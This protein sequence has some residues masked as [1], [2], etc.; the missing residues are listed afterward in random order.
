MP[1]PGRARPNVVIVQTD[2]QNAKPLGFMKNVE[3]SLAAHGATFTNYLT[4]TPQCCPSRATLLTGQYSHNT[5]VLGDNPPLGGFTR[6]NGE[7]TLPVWLHGAGYR[8]AH[9]GKYLNHYDSPPI[10]PHLIPPGWDDWQTPVFHTSFQQYDYTLNQNGRLVHYGHSPRDYETNVLK[11][12]AVAFLRNQ[13]HGSRPFFLSVDTSAPHQEGPL[14]GRDVPRNP[15]PAPG[16]Y[17]KFAHRRLPQPPSFNKPDLTPFRRRPPL[18]SADIAFLRTL[19]RSR[20]ESLLAVDRL[21]GRLV[22]TLRHAGQLE[23]TLFIFTSDN[24]FLLGQHRLHGKLLPYEESIKVPLVIRGPGIPQGVTRSQLVGNIDIAPTVVATTGANPNLRMDGTSL[25]PIARSAERLRH[26]DLLL[27]HL[28]AP[29][30]VGIRTPR[31]AYIC[32][33]RHGA[34]HHCVESELYDLKRD[35]YELRN[36]AGTRRYAAVQ[37]DLRTRLRALRHCAGASCMVR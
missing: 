10:N 35:P 27:E 36:V 8:T 17:G 19:Y 22:A 18:N 6:L 12:K 5:G 15:R 34:N 20:L 23:N 14:E 2:D 3:R 37:A 4:T 33:L 9:L 26:R 13:A 25:L 29:K 11:R 30:Y 31:Y 16:D 1:E 32:D 28:V 7:K 21:V 24:G